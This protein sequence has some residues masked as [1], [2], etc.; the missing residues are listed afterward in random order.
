[1]SSALLWQCLKNN[2]SFIRK[3]KNAPVMTTEPGNLVGINCE[4]FSGFQKKT[5]EMTMGKK[6]K[7]IMTTKS[8]GRRKQRCPAKATH[9][10]SLRTQASAAETQIDKALVKTMYRADLAKVAK[11]KYNKLKLA[12]R[13][14]RDSR[15]KATA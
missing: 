7:V 13:K 3:Q 4:R 5:V 12:A 2:S 9:A 11:H 14:T 6:G 1:M 15:I 10:M 8:A